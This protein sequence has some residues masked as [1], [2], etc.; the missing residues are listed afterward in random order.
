MAP[1]AVCSGGGITVNRWG[2]S[3]QFN[4]SWRQPTWYQQ[5]VVGRIRGRSTFSAWI[6]RVKDRRSN[7]WWQWWGWKV[8]L[9]ISTMRWRGTRLIRLMKWIRKFI[10]KTTWVMRNFQW[11]DCWWPSKGDSGWGAS[12]VKEL[13]TVYINWRSKQV[14]WVRTF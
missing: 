9:S 6:E 7:E 5:A 12:T 14:G 11:G 8:E 13:E 2:W 1:L 4:N 3:V 10:P